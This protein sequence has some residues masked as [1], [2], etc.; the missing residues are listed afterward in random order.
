MAEAE[1][2]AKVAPFSGS[3]DSGNPDIPDLNPAFNGKVVTGNPTQWYN[4]AAFLLPI[5]G[6]FENAGRD[7]L[8]GPGL[9]SLD[10]S[11]F[12]KISISER[13]NAQ[14]KMEIFNLLNHANFGPPTLGVFSGTTVS[15]SADHGCQDEQAE[16]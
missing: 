9:T 7:Q 14:F 1:E 2:I 15:R 4:P 3:G 11:L 5:A 16:P 8:L 10:T 13:W 12:K 6:T